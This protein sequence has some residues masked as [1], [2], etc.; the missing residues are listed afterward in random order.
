M[1]FEK[2]SLILVEYA[3]RLKD[4]D[5]MIDTTSED[6]ARANAIYD[7]DQKYGPRLV[8]IGEVHYPVLKGLQEGLSE[9]SVGE[10]KTIEVEPEKGWGARDSKKVRMYS[11]RKLGKDA[12]RYSIGDPVE[13]DG[14]NGVIR[15]IGSGRIQID[16]NHPYAGKTLVYETTVTGHLE[17]PED[18]IREIL[19]HGLGS[20]ADFDIDSNA[21]TVVLSEDVR[22]LELSAVKAR[23][24]RG[25]FKFAPDVESVQYVEK[26]VNKAKAQ[27]ADSEGEKPA[28]PDTDG[29]GGTSGGH[30]A[31][32][33]DYEGDDLV[34]DG[35][36][37]DDDDDDYDA[38]D[39]SYDEPEKADDSN[40]SNASPAGDEKP[41]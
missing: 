29:V 26:Y 30:D 21:V 16:F 19:Q 27:P 15:F 7:P 25:I 36:D 4:E 28:S 33:D 35:L 39:D 6:D 38:L 24:A 13:I 20:D 17:K 40:S 11:Q 22:P 2:G 14:K 41:A 9:M 1:T 31:Q 8:S 12:E 3:L 10:G 32:S 37:D 23:I 34:D 5:K 18:V